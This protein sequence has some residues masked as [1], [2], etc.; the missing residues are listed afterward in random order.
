[1]TFRGLTL[2][3][4]GALTLTLS[5]CGAWNQFFGGGQAA[6]PPPAPT[7]TLIPLPTPQPRPS[8]TSV[9]PPVAQAQPKAAPGVPGVTDVTARFM[10]NKV[11]GSFKLAGE[12]IQYVYTL[13]N[14]GVQGNQLQMTGIINYKRANGQ[15]GNVPNVTAIISTEGESCER[16]NLDMAPVAVP[17]LNTTIPRQ[18]VGFNLADIPGGANAAVSAMCQLARTVQAN[19]NNPMVKFLLDQVNRQLK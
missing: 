14:L 8:L 16:V 7:A 15:G 13:Q 18:R 19:P 5:G 17:E 3:L 1:M 12:A 4:A 2:I 6:A 9:P 10:G 11:E